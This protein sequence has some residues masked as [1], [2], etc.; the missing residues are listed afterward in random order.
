M[1]KE[2]LG[3]VLEAF[4]VLIIAFILCALLENHV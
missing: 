2:Q 4:I 1:K 3:K